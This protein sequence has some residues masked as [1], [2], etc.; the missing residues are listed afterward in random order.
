[1]RAP[2]MLELPRR[3]A[4]AIVAAGAQRA[5]ALCDTWQRELL[6]W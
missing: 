1:M 4:R 2:Y 6:V 5:L 3:A